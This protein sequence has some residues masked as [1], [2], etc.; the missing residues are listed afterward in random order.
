M[1]DLQDL[2][3]RA[4]GKSTLKSL[5]SDLGISLIVLSSI[6]VA[7][8][9]VLIIV[10]RLHPSHDS[11]G[12]E[13][14]KTSMQSLGVIVVGAMAGIATFTYQHKRLRAAELLDEQHEDRRREVDRIR[15]ERHRQDEL[16]RSVLNDTLAAYHAVKRTRRLLD[17]E[18]GPEQKG[19]VSFE[20]YDRYMLGIND[21]QLEF[22]K[23]KLL[24]DIIDDS[25]LPRTPPWPDAREEDNNEAPL[26]AMFSKIEHSLNELVN[27][28]KDKRLEVKQAGSISLPQ[29]TQA[30]L[31][32]T[33]PGFRAA[34]ARPKDAV[35]KLLQTAL[36]KPI[37]LPTVAEE[38]AAASPKERRERQSAASCP[39]VVADSKAPVP[40]ARDKNG[41]G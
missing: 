25:R 13:L 14:A 4:K 8:V 6:T 26:V 33:S 22:E 38:V 3:S 34:I 7:S 30:T 36:L 2:V 41:D 32:V 19:P 11:L 20:I 23:L 31:F 24:A 15:D 40:A 17:A 37:D 28:Y 29:L 16:L 18:A 10:W 1:Q 5:F 12:F 27:E 39:D 9:I 21:E 35:V